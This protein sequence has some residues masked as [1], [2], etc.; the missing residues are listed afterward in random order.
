MATFWTEERAQVVEQRHPAPYVVSDWKTPSGHIHVGSLRGVLVHDA[1]ARALQRR[2]HEV[3]YYYGFDDVDPF[4]KIPSY[5]DQD[6]YR[7][8]LGRSM[9]D[10]PVPDSQGKPDG[11]DVTP[12]HNYARYYA[13]E[14]EA[15]Y[16]QLGVHSKT[17]W[18]G[19]LYDQGR[20]NQAIR[21]ILDHANEVRAAFEAVVVHRTADRMDKALVAEFPVNVRCESCAKVATTVVTA[22]NGERVRYQCASGTVAWAEGCGHEGETSP[23][24]GRS[25]LPWKLDWPASWFVLQS[26]IEGAGKDHYTK[27]GSRDVGVEVFRR[28]FQPVAAA[29]HQ[30]P[31]EDLFYEWL[32]EEGGKKMS[33]SKAVGAKASDMLKQLPSELLRFLLVRTRPVS[34]VEFRHAATTVPQLFDEYDRIVREA[35]A[36]D[37]VAN[38]L[39]LASQIDR[40]EAA[41]MAPLKFS[42]VSSIVQLP[43]LSV[44]AWAAQEL[45]RE[46]TDRERELLQLREHAATAWLEQFP[47]ERLYTLRTDPPLEQLTDLEQVFVRAL[48][49]SLSE[50]VDWSGGVIQEVIYAAANDVGLPTK[51][52][53]AVLYR[54][55]LGQSSGPRAGFLFA[56]LGKDLVLKRLQEAV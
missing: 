19:E 6:A 54:L 18:K 36:G 13:E 14:F 38:A 37:E 7:P 16:R 5:L 31:P 32:Y 26:D 9:R 11:Q 52:G 24:H 2:G 8:Y 22:W 15:V 33:T 30:Q 48:I 51:Q 10:L 39:L 20:F 46:M 12:T 17:L 42:T 27:G 49:S 29:G 50:V 44:V 1:V 45:E 21:L 43:R 34:G 28:I 53:F 40:Q 25:K 47:E 56:Q 41:T 4:D 3:T 23:F 35:L 55:F